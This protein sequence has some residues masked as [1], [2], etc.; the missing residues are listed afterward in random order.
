MS[1]GERCA[2]PGS[3]IPAA[4][5]AL[6]LAGALVPGMPALAEA[7]VLGYRVI[8]SYPHDPSAF[9]QG[10]AYVDGQLFEGTGNYGES[11]LRRVELET[12]LVQQ[13]ARLPRRL[14]GEGIA[15]WNGRIAQLTWREGVGLVYDQGSLRRLETF[16]ISGEGWGL[17]HDD[18]HWIMSNGSAE[19]AFLDPDTW[20]VR[21][22]LQVRD[23]D[24][25]VRHLNEL[26]YVGGEVWA[27]IWHQDS[28]VRIDPGSGAVIGYV[29]LGELYP[30]PAE[31]RRE[32]VLNG[33]AYDADGG[34]LFVTGKYWPRLFEIQVIPKP[35]AS[36]EGPGQAGPR[37]GWRQIF[38]TD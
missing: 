35:P 36:A 25:P 23:G 32:A 8:A 15:V 34:R 37:L 9:T 33:I 13:E 29:D 10:L 16:P 5:L 17:T 28:I 12:G 22:R 14:F 1:A 30:D 38:A 11:F 2:L 19:L 21:R 6:G 20:E 3:A 26:E 4:V 27:N 24:R 18:R 31:R 7:P